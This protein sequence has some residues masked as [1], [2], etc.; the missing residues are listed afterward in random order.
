MR[1]KREC[2]DM[3]HSV[4]ADN[5]VAGGSGGENLRLEVKKTHSVEH[6]L[7]RQLPSPS[8]RKVWFGLVFPF[9]CVRLLGRRS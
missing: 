3:L 9:F 5:K 6:A 8:G 7:R 1:S 2:D 4:D